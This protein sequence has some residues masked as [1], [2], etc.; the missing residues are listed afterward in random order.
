MGNKTSEFGRLCR[1]YRAKLGLN[2][3][4]AAEK[5]GVKQST[6]TKIEQGGQPVS[7]EFIKN[8]IN[9]YQ[10][11]DWEEKKEFLLTYLKNSK[12]FEIQLDQFG[13]IRKELLAALCIQWEVDEHH[14][15]GWYDF[16]QLVNSF[17]KSLY[18]ISE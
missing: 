13:P 10:I 15:K 14:S 18:N 11:K 6:I 4:Q 8:S 2:M 3:I 12:R 7:F 17:G 1:A 5:I 16:F 9:V